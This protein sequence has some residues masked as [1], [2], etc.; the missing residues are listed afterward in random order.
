[1]EQEGEDAMAEELLAIDGITGVSFVSDL[2]TQVS[3]MMRSLDMVVV[4]L[5]VSAGLLAFIVLYNLNNISIIERRREL[6]TLKVLGFYDGEVAAY[7]YR[8]NIWLTLI[9]MVLGVGIGFVLHKFIIRTCEV[10]MIMF[11]QSI[12]LDSYLYSILLT[13]LF[14]VLV[15]LFMFFKLRKI[16]MVESLK[17]VE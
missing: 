7:I 10:D 15:N 3:D 16:D 17:S 11:G 6:A 9:G 2:Q 13:V 14:S 4:V 8:E 5:V 12:R 1:M